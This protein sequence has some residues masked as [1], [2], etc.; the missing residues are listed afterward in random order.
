MN[1]EFKFKAWD[2]RRKKWVLPESIQNPNLMSVKNTKFGFKFPNNTFIYVQSVGL[3]DIN[4]KDIYEGDLVEFKIN[5][6][7][8][9]AVIKWENYGFY[10][11]EDEYS[12]MPLTSGL[13][14]EI[15]GNVFE[16]PNIWKKA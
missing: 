2:T 4:K 16:T 14:Y 8:T 6:K 3:K 9:L 11:N 1:R 5:K 10:L 12:S 15:K 7:L 13:A